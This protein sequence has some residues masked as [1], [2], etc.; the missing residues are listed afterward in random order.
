MTTEQNSDNNGKLK[1]QLK[2]YAVYAG[3]AILFVGALWLI[4][5]PSS[6]QKEEEMKTS[7]L[8]MEVPQPTQK[9]IVSDKQ[10]AYDMERAEQLKQQRMRTLNDF[11]DLISDGTT[12]DSSDPVLSDPVPVKT[13]ATSSARSSSNASVNAYRDMNKTLGAFYQTDRESEETRQLKEELE[14]LK[15]QL[16]DKGT[17]QVTMKDQL[18]LMEKSYQMASKYLPVEQGATAAATVH[19]NQPSGTTKTAGGKADTSPVGGVREQTVSALSQGMSDLE[20]VEAYSVERNMGFYSAVSGESATGK[21]TIRACI[22]DDQTVSYG[23][24]PQ[25]NVRIR[26]E[27][28]M[29]VGGTVIPMHT[30]VTGMARIGERLEI[31]VTSIEYMGNIYG[32]NIVI[33][34]TDGQAGITIPASLE[35]NAAKEI[36]ANT[37]S[38]MGSSFTFSSSAGQQIAADVGRGVVQGTSQYI[39]RK[40]R[41][42]KIHLK[43]GHK[44]LLLPI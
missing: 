27:E 26:L 23:L 40:M 25:R 6:K 43:A 11:T 5:S 18:E 37:G 33:Y 12:V 44:V 19:G 36:A 21:N 16:D 24:E 41:V 9:E 17:P 35:I 32:V 20:F 4:Y 13:K 28:P 30:I 39:S 31:T 1:Q 10:K 8:N 34:D 42:V 29:I 7:G 38:S 3:M 22:H 2:K 14:S 15:K